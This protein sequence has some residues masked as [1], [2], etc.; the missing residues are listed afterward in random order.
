MV[1]VPVRIGA[2]ATI[3]LV[4]SFAA[5]RLVMSMPDRV[6]TNSD[7]GNSDVTPD[8]SFPDLPRMR[9]EEALGHLT[10]QAQDVLNSQGRLRALLRANAAVASDL[11]L[12]VVLRQ[13]VSAARELVGAR[14]AALGVI[15]R[16]GSL[17]QFVH[18]GMDADAVSRIGG[19]PTG[20]GILGELIT[21]P[22]PLRLADLHEHP[23]SAGFPEHHPPMGSFLG[24]PI[25]V[26]NQI[27]G[28]LYLTERAHGEFSDE[29]EQLITALASTAGNAIEN[30]RLFE[31]ASQHRHWLA[32]ST[33]VTQQLFAATADQP[34]ELVLRLAVQGAQAD[35]ANL[36]LPVG[37]DPK[38][39][40]SV[41][42]AAGVLADTVTGQGVDD[43]SAL[44][45]VIE[46]GKPLL[47]DDCAA[48][49]GG[50]GIY[51]Q[52]ELGIGVGSMVC[53][54]LLTG[55]QVVGVL[56]VGRIIGRARFTETDMDQLAVFAGHAGLALE[57]DRARADRDALARVEDHDRIAADLH[58]H[59]IQ[60]L[61][62]TGMGL[63]G[64]VHTVPRPEH[65]QRL[66]GYV[67]AIDNT[68][69]RIR[70]T[71]FELQTDRQPDV[72]GLREALLAVSQDETAALGFT[73]RLE[74]KGLLDTIPLDLAEDVVAVVREALSNT[75][76]HAHASRVSVRV[77]SADEVVTVE[78]TDDGDGIGSAIRS[79]GLTN[80]RRR[81][82]AR[83]GT[84][85]L[86]TPAGGGTSLHWNARLPAAG[87]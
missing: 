71:I 1:G 87:G 63:E 80:L 15:G 21:H 86:S 4:V 55:E 46:S 81:A 53:A 65:R 32:A 12:P 41:R 64:R 11:S 48:L 17:E 43:G 30:A 84:L 58:D 18:V 6:L 40:W 47:V 27:Y 34:L 31:E 44:G 28:N 57:L 37:G 26:R 78:V 75:A 66:L 76:R 77:C 3:T 5:P 50:A 8:L 52:P 49:V 67:D 9:L 79:S 83:G 24:V 19:L 51:S 14:Y 62:A 69:R 85:E 68:I 25:R 36:V 54:P 20:R 45:Q 35:L 74:Y 13:I 70:A 82:E 29:D 10:S 59:V 42:T 39:G 23:A 7:V 60:E 73:P 72:P 38:N 16:N 2:A 22:E 56:S 33:E 61:F